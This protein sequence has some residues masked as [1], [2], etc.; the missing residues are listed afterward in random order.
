[1]EISHPNFNNADDSAKAAWVAGFLEA[2]GRLGTKTNTSPYSAFVKG[3]PS[4]SVQ[5]TFQH[6]LA[7]HHPYC[8][9]KPVSGNIYELADETLST[10]L[11]NEIYGWLYRF[12]GYRRPTE[13][14]GKPDLY[15]ERR[16]T[17]PTST[18]YISHE[19]DY[20]TEIVKELADAVLATADPAS[21]TLLVNAAGCYFH[22]R[23]P[24]KDWLL[25][26]TCGY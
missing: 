5:E 25:I 20:R 24:T 1:M 13:P 22:F 16:F 8:D 12:L 15:F 11:E 18:F 23:S 4:F 26:L 9:D 3:N 19:H 14:Y 10:T 7:D 6:C 17:D 21:T 2:F